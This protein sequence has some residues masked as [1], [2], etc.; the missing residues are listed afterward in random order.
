MRPNAPRGDANTWQYCQDCYDQW[1]GPPDRRRSGHVTFRDKASQ[2]MMKPTWRS[3][4][5][6]EEDAAAVAADEDD[7]R[8][9][10]REHEAEDSQREDLEPKPEESEPE[11]EPCASAPELVADDADEG[12]GCDDLSGSELDIA[13]AIPREPRP[14]LEQYKVKWANI[15]ALHSKAVEGGFSLDN[16]VPVPIHELWQ[17]CPYV[18]FD[19]LKSEEAQARLSVCKPIS[20]L[21][22]T[23]RENGVERY[24]HNAGGVFFQ[25]RS[26]L[27]LASTLGFVLDRQ[28]GNFLG[29]RPEELEALHEILVWGREPGR[30]KILAFFGQTLEDFSDACRTLM[31]K[32]KDVLPKGNNL[33]RVRVMAK[34]R[35]KNVKESSLGQTLGEET[36]GMVIVDYD[37]HPIRYNQLTVFED[38]VAKHKSVRFDVEAVHD[39][40]SWKRAHSSLEIDEGTLDDSMREKLAGGARALKEDTFVKANDPHMDAKVFPWPLG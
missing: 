3:Q 36:T 15:L 11:S 20:G 32:F 25:K 34:D 28:S 35:V 22:E 17:D 39:G 4:Q 1:I 14:T 18:P 2:C 31:A 23:T 13:P 21:Q 26:P 19:K 8:E 24:A 9:E 33:V 38:I 29:L 5:Q 40:R 12:E 30:N 6:R 10:E 27:Q 37:G 16:L 7:D